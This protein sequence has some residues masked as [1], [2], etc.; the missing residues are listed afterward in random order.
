[1]F[2]YYT[3]PRENSLHGEIYTYSLLGHSKSND[4]C[5]KT[6]NK[7]SL[8]M[9]NETHEDSEKAVLSEY[10]E[11]DFHVS[12]DFQTIFLRPLNFLFNHI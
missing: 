3:E 6:A 12:E 4:Q 1:M 7:N 5:R 11:R 10:S 9:R 8:I 2:I